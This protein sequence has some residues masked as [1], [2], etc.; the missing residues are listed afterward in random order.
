MFKLFKILFAGCGL[1]LVLSGA[2]SAGADDNSDQF[3]ELTD[4]DLCVY[5]TKKGGSAWETVGANFQQYI[6][7]ARQRA[8]NLAMCEALLSSVQMTPPDASA[9]GTDNKVPRRP[10]SS[11]PPFDGQY[12][13]V[14]ACPHDFTW[15]IIAAVTD[16]IMIIRGNSGWTIEGAFDANGE[17]ILE[18]SF[19][20]TDRRSYR[21][22]GEARIVDGDLEGRSI[23]TGNFSPVSCAFNGVRL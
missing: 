20:T 5:A 10:A 3:P 22:W 1:V 23:Y 16:G 19:Q 18:G 2:S 14:M 4:T 12:Q 17:I 15:K 11:K 8:L 6:D 9:A 21:F 7:A 13:I